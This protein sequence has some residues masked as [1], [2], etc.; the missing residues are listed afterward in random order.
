MKIL[1]R[2]ENVTKKY[3]GAS[4][5]TLHPTS[6]HVAKGTV[7]VIL[8][9]SGSGKT[10]LLNIMSG[11]DEPS[12][13][14]VYYL[15]NNLY[16]LTDKDVSFL[17]G[18]DFGY[19]FQS[20]QLIDELTIFDNICLPLHFTKQ[21]IIKEEV[22]KLASELGIQHKLSVFPQSLSGGEQ[23]RVAIARAMIN[24]PKIIFADEPTANLDRTNSSQVVKLL[25]QLCKHHG[26][27]LILVTHEENL[28]SNP[29]YLYYMEEGNLN[30]R[31]G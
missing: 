26:V 7:N 16:Q 5:I 29:D 21:P 27:T 3:S 10:T 22:K 20:F 12:N 19:I 28:I 24:K 8:G 15:S 18:K 30:L 25:F 31:S 13:G 2:I 14:N 6:F 23:Q 17:R 1:L 9:K 4:E 11:M